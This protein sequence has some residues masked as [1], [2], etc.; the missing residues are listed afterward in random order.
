M[1]GDSC[2]GQI[3]AS[4]Q[5]DD[6]R[7]W[8]RA[9]RR[10]HYTARVSP[11]RACGRAHRQ[12]LVP[13]SPRWRPAVPQRRLCDVRA[14]DLRIEHDGRFTS[15]HWAPQPP[16]A[17]APTVM[18]M[19][20][21]SLDVEWTQAE[22]YPG[23][24]GAILQWHGPGEG[25]DASRQIRDWGCVLNGHV[26]ARPSRG[27]TPNEFGIHRPRDQHTR[28]Y[29]VNGAAERAEMSRHAV[30]GHA[31]ALAAMTDLAIILE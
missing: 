27:L 24:S 19:E 9:H 17:P 28:R 3:I 30:D 8:H 4:G 7:R 6:R 1:G 21:R 26:H 13:A 10:P 15:R 23:H 12:R 2:G 25:Y 16:A 5:I 18:P 31:A 14:R 22:A 29:A 11:Q 20:P